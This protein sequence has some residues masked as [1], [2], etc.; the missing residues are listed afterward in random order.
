MRFNS[1]YPVITELG[2]SFYCRARRKEL[3]LDK[4]LND[5]LEANAFENRRSACFRCPQGR[6]NRECFAAG[7]TPGDDE[8]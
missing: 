6:K 5:Y 7:E 8:A 1:T 4:C 3:S 2:D